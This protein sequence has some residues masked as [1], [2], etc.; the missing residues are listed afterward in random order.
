V[1]ELLA[2]YG[3]LKSFNL[4]MDKNTGKSKVRCAQ[5]LIKAASLPPHH[6]HKRSHGTSQRTAHVVDQN[7]HQPPAS[8]EAQVRIKRK[9]LLLSIYLLLLLLLCSGLRVLRVC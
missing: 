1:K 3:A 4:V 7:V 2:P 5:M 8:D 6:G 9:G